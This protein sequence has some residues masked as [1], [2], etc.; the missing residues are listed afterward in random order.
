MEIK[1]YFE[2]RVVAGFL[3]TVVIL[4]TLGLFSYFSTQ[5]L[6]NTRSLLTH[7]MSVINNTDLIVKHVVDMETGQRGYVITGN[8]AFLEPFYNSTVPLALYIKALDSLTLA[9]SVQSNR[10]DTLQELINKQKQWTTRVIEARKKSFENASN[11]VIEGTGKRTT[12]KIRQCAKRLQRLEEITFSKNNTITGKSIQQFQYS[13]IGFAVAILLIILYLFYVL[14]KSLKARMETES[15]LQTT[16]IE[17][18]DL[19]ANA[20][21]GYFSVDS[22]IRISNINQTL[23]NWMGYKEG[24]V[25][26]KMMF[27]DLLT[28]QSKLDFNRSFE[29]DF[30]KYR[31]L[32]YVN[33]LEYYFIRK[34]KTTFP[35]SINSSAVFNEKGDFIRSRSTVFDNSERKRA[36][37]N[38]LLLNQEL[39]SK[40]EERTR[41]LLESQKIYKSIASNIPGSSI[42]II[43]R[44]ERYLLAEGDLLEQMGFNKE[45][46][47]N[48]KVIDLISESR[49]NVLRPL[50]QHAF[51]GRTIIQELKSQSGRDVVMRVVPLKDEGDDYF[52]VMIV[53]IDISEIKKAQLELAELNSSLEKN[54]IQR[55]AQL[56]ELNQELEAFTYSVSH[57]LRAPLRIIS[58]YSQLLKEDYYDKLD[59]EGQRLT[60]RIIKNSIRMGQLIDDLLNFSKL[61]RVELLRTQVNM[62]ELAREVTQDLLQQEGNRKVNIVFQSLTPV[63]A[64]A[65]LLRQVWINLLSNA[66]K[67][68]RKKDVTEIEIGAYTEGETICY[69]VRDHGAGFDMAY[70]D[71]LFR[72]FQRL[73][74]MAEFEGTGVGL[75][76]IF[77]IIKRHGG[78]V[79]AEGKINEGATFYFSLP[80]LIK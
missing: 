10:V 59:E 68:S 17:T 72:V 56:N 37:N 77:T 75:A 41:K 52:A 29:R 63:H 8:E 79:W 49:Y 27:E 48:S 26:G 36:E 11:L 23:L 30:E 19:Y 4:L 46:M 32:G 33:D 3:L 80:A 61:G 5:R 69:Y 40:V 24:E 73:H 43:D 9:D 76:L 62:D 34:D 53:L 7:Q 64:D 25:I 57:D 14:N 67:Y 47:V 70:A 13:F 39:E 71:K 35:V 50:L 55:T 12:D 18:R 21:C 2:K 15:I 66:L 28:P 45:T 60:D 54:V 38:I 31:T 65:S 44:E 42:T 78:R 20:P 1:F 6:I 51:S 22:T 74:T 58:G 16:A